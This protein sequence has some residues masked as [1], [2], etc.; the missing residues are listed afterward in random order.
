MKFRSTILVL[1]NVLTLFLSCE[2]IQERDD[3]QSWIGNCVSLAVGQATKTV[4]AGLTPIW[5]ADDVLT[6]F[7]NDGTPV[8]FSNAT[9]AGTTATFSTTS[10]TGKVPVC[11]VY[12]DA[13][14]YDE[15]TGVAGITI[16]S[17]Q[18][19]PAGSFASG[20]N[21]SIGQVTLDDGKY[22]VS[23]MKNVATL[24][25]FTFTGDTDIVSLTIQSGSGEQIRSEERR[26]GNECRS[27]WSPYH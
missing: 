20:A 1:A 4:L 10:W 9:G 12:S 21:P 23:T 27:R 8:V 17:A 14:T 25:S 26:V 24:L 3:A 22:T 6:V 2:H 18:N 11:A 13:P 16:P 15:V 7:D 5:S 19:A